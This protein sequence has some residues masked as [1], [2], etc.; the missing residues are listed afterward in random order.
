MYGINIKYYI[1]EMH[2]YDINISIRV[3]FFKEMQNSC[4]KALKLL[5][6]IFTCI[7]CVSKST[8]LQYGT[9]RH[10]AFFL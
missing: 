2:F 3:R 9:D 6:V 1:Y 7:Q 8:R 5:S 10:I 4:T